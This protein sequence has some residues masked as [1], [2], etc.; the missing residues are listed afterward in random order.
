MDIPAAPVELRKSENRR[1]ENKNRN[2][3]SRKEKNS[4]F[5]DNWNGKPGQGGR[6]PNQGGNRPN[7]KGGKLS[8]IHIFSPFRRAF[9]PSTAFWICA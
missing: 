4:K 6:R 3:D 5:N 7:Q 2:D 9:W 8:L 1:A